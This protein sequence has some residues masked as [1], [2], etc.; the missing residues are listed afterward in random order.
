MLH[1]IVVFSH[2]MCAFESEAS[3]SLFDPLDDWINPAPPTADDDGDKGEGEGKGEGKDEPKADDLIG[4]ADAE[5]PV[6]GTSASASASATVDSRSHVS[7]ELNVEDD[8]MRQ[9]WD[10]LRSHSI[11]LFKI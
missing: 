6:E 7:P 9:A 11:P 2:C 8:L 1:E 3:L 4:A 5:V 10:L